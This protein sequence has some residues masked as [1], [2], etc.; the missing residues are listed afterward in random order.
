MK[1]VG[2]RKYF[3]YNQTYTWL[4]LIIYTQGDKYNLFCILTRSRHG[5][6][7]MVGGL[8]VVS[9]NSAHGEVYL[10]QLYVIKFVSNLWQVSGFLRVLW[11][12]HQ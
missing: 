9:S 2:S 4:Y 8:K 10:M 1:F 11:F 6:V 12:R 3:H 7:C 5:R